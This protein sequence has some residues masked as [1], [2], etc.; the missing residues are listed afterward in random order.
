MLREPPAFATGGLLVGQYSFPLVVLSVVISIIAAYAALDLGARVTHSRGFTRLLWLGGGA[1]AMGIGI[2]AM[3]YIG[4][5]AFGLP[6]PVQYDWPTVLLSLLAAVCASGVALVVVSRPQMG[7]FRAC[8]GSIFMGAGIAAMHYI[9][10]AAMRLAAMCHY[11]AP[12]VALSVALAI[13]ISFVALWLTFHLRADSE[14]RAGLKAVSAVIMGAAIP[15]MHYTGMAAASF[16]SAPL[17]GDLAHAVSISSLGLAGIVGVTLTAL[18]LVLLTSTADRRVS[19]EIDQRE[20]AEQALRN[21]EEQMRFALEAA[22]IGTW[23]TDLKTGIGHWSPQLGA[24]H[25]VKGGTFPATLGHFIQSVHPD[26]RALVRQSIDDG[27]RLHTDWNVVYRA[28]WPDGSVRAINEIGRAFYDEQGEPF[29]TAGVGID[30]TERQRLEMDLRQAQKMDAIGQLA[31][32]VA[33]DF[34]NLLV[35]IM[36]FTQMSLTALEPGHRIRRDLEAVMKAARSA[37]ALTRQ[38]LAFSRKQILQPQ[39]LDLN[40]VVER[41]QELLR[42]TIGEEV[43]LVTRPGADIGRVSAD[44]GQIEQV[45]MNLVVNARDAMPRG[46]VVT[47]STQSVTLDNAYV[48]THPGAIAGSHAMI[49]ITDTGSG[50]TEAVRAHLF[51]PFFTTKEQ[52]K[53]TGLGLATVYGIVKQSGGFIWVDTRLGHGTT[54]QIYLPRADRMAT[55]AAPSP[56]PTVAGGAETILLVE[57]QDHVRA[58]V[59][60]TLTRRGYIVLEAGGGDDALRHAGDHSTPIDLLLTDVV[61]PR[62]NGRDLARRLAE[63]RPSLRVLYMSGH[64][65]HAIVRRGVIE[66]GLHFIQKPFSPDDLLRKVRVTLDAPD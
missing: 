46:G 55:E 15:V 49:A 26:D 61:M 30:V 29:R 21:T 19:I 63:R 50:M 57:D 41:L 60:A 17:S 37:E 36:G 5:L 10:M 18:G 7:L 3:H 33:H 40:V 27:I 6:I 16:T 2:W 54:F 66:K 1:T 25:G 59:A 56:S 42:R 58:V 34:N 38:L 31:G 64:A 53:G 28:V 44:P 24:L 14:A 20:R 39:I 9:G 65:D 43:Q 4:M 23:E 22:G 8:V 35:T 62:M 45:V 51:E 13:V 12:I 32:G 47:I 48:E 11:S 52:R